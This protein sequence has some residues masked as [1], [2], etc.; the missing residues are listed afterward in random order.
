[1]Y[2]LARCCQPIPGEPIVG[3]VTRGRGITIHRRDCQNAAELL[4]DSERALKVDWS[5]EGGQAFVVRLKLIVEER[6]NILRD[7]ADAVAKADC[8]VRSIGLDGAGRTTPGYLVVEVKN[9][10]HL[11][12]VTKELKKVKGM[13]EVE[14]VTEPEGEK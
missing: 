6:K 1:M 3:F 12:R 4:T 14:R 11:E 8:N 2:R 9:V 13:I 7:V 5:V 10:A